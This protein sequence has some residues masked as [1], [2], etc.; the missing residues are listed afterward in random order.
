MHKTIQVK[1]Q[2]ESN[3][4]GPNLHDDGDGDDDN[5]VFEVEVTI[6]YTV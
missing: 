4:A 6:E 2:H 3:L 5:G 1:Q